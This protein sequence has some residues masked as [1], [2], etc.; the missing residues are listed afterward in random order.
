LEVVVAE[1]HC[2][3][4]PNGIA[5]LRGRAGVFVIVDVLSFSTCVD[6]ATGRGAQILPF[7]LGD[8]AAAEERAR[9]VGALVATHRMGPGPYSL[10]PATLQTIPAGTRLVLPS[11]NGSKLSVL[12]AQGGAAVFAGGLRNASAVAKAARATGGDIAVIPAGER[13]ESDDSLRPAI[14]DLI[15][16]GAIL[17]A[18]DLSLSPE[19]R[20][21]RDAFRAAKDDLASIVGGSM[22]GRELIDR[23]YPQDVAL[24][25]QYDVSITAPRLCDGAYRDGGIQSAV[26]K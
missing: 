18:L 8:H 20:V 14:E 17:E 2:E 25:V 10:S 12:A 7:P 22:S 5:S 21:A 19:A 11:P 15:G 16:A 6:I 9:E 1:A 23:G 24:A 4:G 13:W 3:W 26:S